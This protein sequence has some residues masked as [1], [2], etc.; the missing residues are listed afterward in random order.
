M[1]QKAFRDDVLMFQG[2]CGFEMMMPG[3][4]KIQAVHSMRTFLNFAHVGTLN[5]KAIAFLGDR[6][7]F[8]TPMP[9]LLPVQKPWE[10]TAEKIAGDAAQFAT[11]FGDEANKIKFWKS[12]GESESDNVSAP[13]LLSLPTRFLRFC[14]QGDGCTSS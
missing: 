11:H 14:E 12:G 3:N 10:W 9:V 1:Q 13:C 6:T 7:Q 5:G 2:L 4:Q 8:R